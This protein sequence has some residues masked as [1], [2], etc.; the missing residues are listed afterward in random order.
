MGRT[1]H[2]GQINLCCVSAQKLKKR[3]TP[4]RKGFV[5]YSYLEFH[6]EGDCE[7]CEDSEEDQMMRSPEAKLNQKCLGCL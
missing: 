1:P 7:L 3:K 4:N 5:L 2:S 6:D